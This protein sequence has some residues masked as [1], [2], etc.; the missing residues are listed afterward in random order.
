[1]RDLLICF[2]SD[3]YA[4]P[5]A[6]ERI[7]LLIAALNFDRDA[8]LLLL[9][10]SALAL[11][12]VQSPSFAKSAAAKLQLLELF[13]LEDIFVCS[14]SLPKQTVVPVKE[15]PKSELKALMDEFKNVWIL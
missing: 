9:G 14:S 12:T 10:P 15:L 11:N 7:D 4:T 1:M 13:D 8:A 3:P 5:V 6:Q 2:T